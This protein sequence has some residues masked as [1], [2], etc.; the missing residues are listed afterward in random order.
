VAPGRSRFVH[1]RGEGS[2]ELGDSSRPTASAAWR[3]GE[4][5]NGA[6][7]R[8]DGILVLGSFPKVGVGVVVVAVAVAAADRGI[9]VA[10]WAENFADRYDNDVATNDG[11]DGDDNCSGS[12]SS[13]DY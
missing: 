2:R 4:G 3:D 12:E 13:A 6:E 5:L 8:V 9:S 7:V 10:L 11:S 1:G